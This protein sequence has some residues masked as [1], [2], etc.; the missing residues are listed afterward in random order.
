MHEAVR[1]TANAGGTGGVVEDATSEPADLQ[2]AVEISAERI[3]ALSRHLEETASRRGVLQLIGASALGLGVT[4]AERDESL[5]KRRKNRKQKNR[6]S[7]Q[8]DAG[9]GPVDTLTGIPIRVHDRGRNFKGTLD[10]VEFIEQDGGI[11]AVGELTGKLTGKGFGNRAV[12]ETVELPV[13]L[14]DVPIE[15]V[16]T[17]QL[18][19]EVLHLEL[20]PITLNLLGLNV[21]IG[22]PNNT[23][24]IVDITADPS[25][26]LLGQLLCALAS[27]GPLATIIDLLNQILDILE[28]L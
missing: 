14:P 20:G 4:V 11:V 16:T 10:V 9:I 13:S 21:Y 23:P 1:S 25:G 2:G 12:S 5:A 19:C 28:G 17:Q 26:G 27:G 18:E 24:L 8:Q 3:E 15:G 6:G 22:G 7:K